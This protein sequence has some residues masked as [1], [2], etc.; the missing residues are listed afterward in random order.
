MPVPAG[1]VQ[2]QQA[3]G[4]SWG[5][6]GT[7]EQ[8]AVYFQNGAFV[9]ENFA[10]KGGQFFNVKAYGARG[11]G[12]TDD[13]A[14]I[15]AAQTAAT[16]VGGVVVIPQGTY[17]TTLAGNQLVG[18]IQGHGQI[19]TTDSGN[20]KRGPWFSTVTSPPATRGNGGSVVTAFD[21]SIGQSQLQIEHRVT[22]ATTLGQPSTG[23]LD[24]QESAPVYINFYTDSGYNQQTGGNDG[25]TQLAGIY[26]QGAHFGNGDLSCFNAA[27]AAFGAKAGATSFLAN[28]AAILFNGSAFGGANG[29]YLNPFELSLQDQGFDVA[30]IGAVLSL[31][32][33]VATGALDVCWGGLRVQT[34]GTQPVDTGIILIN[35]NSSGPGFRVGVDL[36][37]T[38]LTTTGTWINAAITL[39][40]DQRIYFQ[41]SGTD[42]G[43]S[44]YRRPSSTGTTWITYDSTLAA[45]NIEV[46]GGSAMQF[47]SSFVR[48]DT[49]SF[50]SYNPG[51]GI[52]NDGTN[53]E[54]A[55]LSWAANAAFLLTEQGGTGQ[56]R[57]LYLGTT[58]SAIVVL[59]S[60]ATDRWAVQSSGHF[61]AV[62]D[63]AIDIGLSGSSR[64]R[65]GYF[66]G[67]VAVKVKAG[68]P[69]DGDF[70]GP[71][72]GMLAV[73]STDNKIYVRI[74]GTWKGVVVA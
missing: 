35:G 4:M 21:G 7:N 26:V 71:V 29:V 49:G 58:G 72:D 69:A 31:H 15:Q 12:V 3:Q 16:A 18:P 2:I 62:T 68:V 67:G 65:N 33:T 34:G 41:A 50:R 46:A 40:Q 55:N 19:I 17:K 57:P 43:A 47:Q 22:G 52:A 11:D 64:P 37:A 53:Y 54:R 32:R 60:N 56:A 30:G 24:N 48:T 9:V 13:T 73:D 74:G 59:R 23:Y 25:R 8:Q 51:D 1:F 70:T 42:S 5:D 45:L 66:A 39:S 63:N 14:A 38:G 10:D 36:S 61:T 6:P 27:N 20:H 44:I 28:P